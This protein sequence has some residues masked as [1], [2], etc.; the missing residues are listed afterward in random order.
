MVNHGDANF[1]CTPG[2][3]DVQ[4]RESTVI[5]CKTEPKFLLPALLFFVSSFC[6][7]SNLDYNLPEQ[8]CISLSLSVCQGTHA[9]PC[10]N[11]KILTKG[12]KMTIFGLSGRQ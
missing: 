9:W 11:R 6:A 4:V 7:I 3:D 5:L 12:G 2:A 8:R 1:S 10:L